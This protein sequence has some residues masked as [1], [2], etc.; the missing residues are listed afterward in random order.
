MKNFEFYFISEFS[1]LESVEEEESESK[2]ETRRKNKNQERR[3]RKMALV[4]F[5]A[6]QTRMRY[7]ESVMRC[8]LRC[9]ENAEG[10]CDIR[11]AAKYMI[12]GV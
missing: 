12:A 1:K 8:G 9:A 6:V 5:C 10:K 3:I 7:V 4:K 2:A 11:K